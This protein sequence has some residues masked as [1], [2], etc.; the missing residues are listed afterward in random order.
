MVMLGTASQV[1]TRYRNH[2]G[3]LLRFDRHG[4]LFDPGEGTQRQMIFAGVSATA[5]NRICITHF[6]GDHCLGLAGITQRISLDAVPHEVPVHFPRSGRKYFDRLRYASI[7]K[8]RAKM[9]PRPIDGNG[10]IAEADGIRLVAMGLDHGVPTYGYRV[11]EPDGVRMLPEKLAAAGV[12][13][14]A[15]GEL[16][17]EGQ[18]T[19]DG[20]VVRLE[21]VSERRVGQKV[22]VIMDTRVCDAAYALADGV[23][24]LVCESTYLSEHAREANDHHHMTARQAAEIARAAGVRKLCLTH[25]SQRYGR[26]EAFAEEAAA[27]F[28]NVVAAVD[29]MRIPVPPRAG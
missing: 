27:V 9:V 10:V 12:K 1:P 21:E 28:P 3:Y 17:R 29:G 13:G 26:V 22:A 11:E 5:I 6:H 2:N 23:D 4:I 18:V 16:Q 24:L 25:F 15:I 19:V 20:T 7:Y 8:D 14:R